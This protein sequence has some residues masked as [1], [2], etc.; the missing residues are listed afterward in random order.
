M[1]IYDLK[2]YGVYFPQL[3]GGGHVRLSTERIE[4][5]ASRGY[6]YKFE[7]T[8]L[9]QYGTKQDVLELQF[10]D[11]H[12]E[13]ITLYE[14]S[15]YLNEGEWKLAKDRIVAASFLSKYEEL[16]EEEAIGS[17]PSIFDLT[18]YGLL[19]DVGLKMLKTKIFLSRASRDRELT[20]NS[21]LFTATVL[22]E[23]KGNKYVIKVVTVDNVICYIP[24]FKAN[25]CYDNDNRIWVSCSESPI[26]GKILKC[27][28]KHLNG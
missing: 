18:F 20:Q 19:E 24:L 3:V 5:R 12:T 10:D 11:G 23:Y 16:K 26:P 2:L 27:Y 17:T 25:M 9:K 4:V 14:P 13:Y 7:V 15:M 1:T 6:V 28:V 22:K 8:A 21:I